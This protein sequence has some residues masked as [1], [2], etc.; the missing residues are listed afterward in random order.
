[1]HHFLPARS[2]TESIIGGEFATF[3]GVEIWTDTP[4][5]P[6]SPSCQS[7]IVRPFAV[8]LPPTAIRY[9]VVGGRTDVF[10]WGTNG[11]VVLIGWAGFGQ[12]MWGAVGLGRLTKSL[13]LRSIDWEI[14]GM[15][16]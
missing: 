10:L 9:L 15:V 11:F 2:H 12:R 5:K 3:Y 16:F 4:N 6:S 7:R 1:M 13:R 14:G 8:F